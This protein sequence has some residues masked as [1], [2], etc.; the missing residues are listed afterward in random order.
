MF[1]PDDYDIFSKQTRAGLNVI[2]MLEKPK[3]AMG[4][5]GATAHLA[6]C[7]ELLRAAADTLDKANRAGGN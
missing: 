7:S 3:T 1:R 4:T 5:I 6:E 2:V